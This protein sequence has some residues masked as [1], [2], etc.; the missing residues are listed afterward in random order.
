MKEFK[1]K[2]FEEISSKKMK[3]INEGWFSQPPV[4]L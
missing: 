2:G 4:F 1:I 3:N